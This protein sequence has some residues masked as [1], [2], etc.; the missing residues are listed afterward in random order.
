MLLAQCGDKPAAPMER[1]S[2]VEVDSVCLDISKPQLYT[3]KIMTAAAVT[4][5]LH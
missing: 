2:A 1:L 3:T 5:V 4:R